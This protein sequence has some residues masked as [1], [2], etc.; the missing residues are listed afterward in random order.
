M[1]G[2]TLPAELAIPLIRGADAAMTVRVTITGD[3]SWRLSVQDL[4]TDDDRG[5]M[6]SA[7]DDTLGSA[8]RVVADDGTIVGL[9]QI[10]E[11]RVA[12]G[13]GAA[14]ELVEIRQRVQAIDRPGSYSITL[15]FTVVA[16]F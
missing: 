6:R 13:I 15:R 4:A 14:S 5:H 8:L 7:A 2:L 3:A 1:L 9:D 12:T 16:S 10:G 11:V